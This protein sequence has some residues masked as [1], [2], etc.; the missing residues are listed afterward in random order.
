M[1]RFL[2][3]KNRRSPKPARDDATLSDTTDSGTDDLNDREKEVLDPAIAAVV[4]NGP[5]N[6]GVPALRPFPDSESD[7]FEGLCTVRVRANDDEIAAAAVKYAAHIRCLQQF[8]CESTDRKATALL[9]RFFVSEA[10]AVGV[11]DPK[12]ALHRGHVDYYQQSRVRCRS[13]RSLRELRNILYAAGRVLHPREFPA[14][15]VLP[16]PRFVRQAAASRQRVR[17]LYALVPGLPTSLSYR[18]EVLL[19]LAYGAGARPTELK[20]LRGNAINGVKHQGRVV[21]VVT[22]PNLAGGQRH[23][24]VFDA[25]IGTRLL[26]R[27]RQ[28]GDRL[29]LAPQCAYAER[30]MINRI[31]EHLVRLGYKGVN[32][33]ELRH[34]WVL[35]LAEQ[36]PAALLLQLADVVDLQ[37][38]ADQR[39]QLPT[40]TLQHTITLMA[41]VRR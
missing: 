7:R 3:S 31:S 34:R 16:A 9:A 28:A 35:D 25:I 10:M 20:V 15:R 19:D 38:L 12:S 26:D 39:G 23:V 41:E 17:D 37:I 32:V 21:T 36:I 4:E 18:L 8:T 14:P 11:L 27:A 22:L 40:Y 29:V 5:R 24:P 13:E 2:S 6:A 1:A 30:N 33:A